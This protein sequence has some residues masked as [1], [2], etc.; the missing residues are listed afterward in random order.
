[1]LAIA[2]PTALSAGG[3]FDAGRHPGPAS[4]STTP[5]PEPER[6][7]A[8]G[9]PLDTRDLPLGEAPQVDWIG[10]TT[11]HRADGNEVAVPG[12]YVDLAPFD[13][14]WLALGV[15]DEGGPYGQQLD[16]DGDP[17]GQVFPSAYSLA[18]SDDG[19]QV[20][21]VRDG[22]LLVHDNGT[23]ED[24]TVR[25]AG[26]STEP[27][28][29]SG[30]VAYYNAG[31]EEGTQTGYVFD[32]DAERRARPGTFFFR[33][34]TDDGWTIGV[35]EVT[36]F[37]TCSVT[38]SPQGED[39]GQTCDFGLDQFS[40][41]GGHVLAGPAYRDGYAD[42]EL[43]VVGVDPGTTQPL[44]HFLQSGERDAAFM[45]YTWEDDEHVLVITATPIQGTADRMF[46]V[47]RVG[48]DGTVE[49]AMEP[50]RAAEFG[51]PFVLLAP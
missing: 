36:D 40:P 38:V 16:G 21:Y 32:G 42:G 31:G 34:V 28:G 8:L 49:N 18:V 9:A 29:F 23:G 15:G 14:G 17:V 33:D 1:V 20:L 48:L 30:D 3:V 27:I 50:V 46:Q 37:G 45:D 6:V 51:N 12:R 39:G 26:E 24:Q 10:G 25:A 2:V 43:A 13:D 5:T 35:T 7:G 47:V 44:L 4:N 22:S 11:L 41:D 19:E